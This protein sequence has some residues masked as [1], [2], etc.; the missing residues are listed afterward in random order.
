MTCISKYF[1]LTISIAV[2]NLPL[3]WTIP[4]GLMKLPFTGFKK[5][6]S[7]W[8]LY[9]LV[10]IM[11]MLAPVSILNLTAVLQIF[12]FFYHG[13]FRFV[14]VNSPRKY[15][16]FFFIY[17]LHHISFRTACY[18]EVI[19]FLAFLSLFPFRWTVLKIMYYMTSIAVVAVAVF[20]LLLLTVSRGLLWVFISSTFFLCIFS[21]WD[22]T[23]SLFPTIAVAFSS[24]W[25]GIRCNLWIGPYSRATSNDNW[26]HDKLW[27]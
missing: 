10:K 17:C 12:K 15:I 2:I 9:V 19:H 7:L 13:L 21:I 22:F 27:N 23:C 16:I 6:F 26:N 11:F 14:S 3:Y 5:C 4:P 8:F 20:S 1:S 18:N 25:S 24:F